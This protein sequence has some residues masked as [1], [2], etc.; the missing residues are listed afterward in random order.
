M[1]LKLD[2][3]KAYDRISWKF[4]LQTLHRLNFN[5]HLIGLI[6]NIISHYSFGVLINGIVSKKFR[7]SRGIRQC[8]PLSTCLFILAVDYLTKNIKHLFNLNPSWRFKNIKGRGLDVLSYAYDT[9]IFSK[10]SDEALEG[11]SALL[12]HYE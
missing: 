9:M 5:T 1:I 12:H 4:I 6:K 10:A 11:I 7:A 8:D 2:I 3:S